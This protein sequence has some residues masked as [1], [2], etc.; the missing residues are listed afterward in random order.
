MKPQ[1]PLIRH[2]AKYSRLMCASVS[3]ALAGLM[4]FASISCGVTDN[5]DNDLAS[6]LEQAAST[7]EQLMQDSGNLTITFPD[8]NPGIPIYARVGPI[9]NQF[10]VTDGQLVI[11]FYRDPECIRDDF[12]FLSYYDPPIAFG[13]ALTVAGT[14]VI[15]SDAGENDFPIMAHTEGTQVPV[16]I[17]DWAGFQALIEAESVTLP[18]IETLNPIKAVAQ[19]F[20]EYLSPRIHD[21]EVIIEAGG[22]ITGTDQQFTFSLTHRG[23]LIERI[24][25][26][27]E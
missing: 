7:F 1:I 9:L 14:F 26:D 6:D 22:T 4:L 11:P 2:I 13:C 25:L 27:I 16:W 5:N 18:A 24:S 10:F 23:D 21:H 19:Q 3:T 12:N 20:Q 17:V 8:E 15:E